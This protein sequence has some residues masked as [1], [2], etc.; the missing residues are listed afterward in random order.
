MI[1]LADVSYRTQRCVT[2]SQM[3]QVRIAHSSSRSVLAFLVAAI[4]LTIVALGATKLSLGP[5]AGLAV[6]IV[7]MLVAALAPIVMWRVSLVSPASVY[8]IVVV[9]GI[10]L[11]SI[12]W[13]GQPIRVGSNHHTEW[14]TRAVFLVAASMIAFWIG[15]GLS[16]APRDIQQ[17]VPRFTASI[18]A[19]SAVFAVGLGANAVLF[20]TGQFSYL[21]SARTDPSAWVQWVYAVPGLRAS[22]ST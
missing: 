15:Y 14:V 3:A 6:A 10:G 20:A 12:A 19:V 2:L 1:Q 18:W 13:F 17:F 5:R 4:A 8:A 22:P 7:A 16:R 11:G 21:A 9:I